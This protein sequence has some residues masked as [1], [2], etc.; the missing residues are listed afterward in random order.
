MLLPAAAEDGATDP[1]AAAHL[2]KDPR[3]YVRGWNDVP[4]DLALAQGRAPNT[5]KK[6]RGHYAAAARVTAAA[7]DANGA[8]PAAPVAGDQPESGKGT[9][10]PPPA[11]PDPPA[12]A[13]TVEA[14]PDVA[15][16]PKDKGGKSAAVGS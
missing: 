11:A 3:Y 16:G 9:A 12:A 15:V 2:N 14:G 10:G 1:P 7:L 13:S 5:A 6:A 8:P 4:A